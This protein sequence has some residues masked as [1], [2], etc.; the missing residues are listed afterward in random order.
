MY[1]KQLARPKRLNNPFWERRVQQKKRDTTRQA[2]IVPIIS[3]G[4]PPPT[5]EYLNWSPARWT[6][7]HQKTY[8]NIILGV[9]TKGANPKG[10]LFILNKFQANILKY[11]SYIKYTSEIRKILKKHKNI[12]SEALKFIFHED[13]YFFFK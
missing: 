10:A 12:K 7:E 2:V 11:D 6:I 1:K 5:L 13:S 3:T 9:N 8:D 4:Y